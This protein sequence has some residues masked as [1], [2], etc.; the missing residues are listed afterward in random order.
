MRDVGKGESDFGQA[1]LDHLDALYGYA[2]AL[3][4]NPTSAE[5]LV[6]ETYLRAARGRQTLEAGS[7]VKSW[8]FAILRNAWLNELRHARSGPEFLA[9]EPGDDLAV[10]APDG[11]DPFTLLVRK[12]E[13]EQ[14]RS[15]IARLQPHHREVIVLRDIEGFSYQEI[16]EI[17]ECPA[18]TVMS[19]LG[20]AREQ[21]RVLLGGAKST[22]GR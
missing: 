3:C 18:G 16:V 1:T 10:R 14:V 11:A 5:D 8:L 17:L 22:A 20:R 21:L 12:I 19:R 13:R 4:R 7:N 6:Q 2:L 15:A 9:I